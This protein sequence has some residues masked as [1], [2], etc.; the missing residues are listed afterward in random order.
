MSVVNIKGNIFTTSS[1]VVVNTINCVGVMG[2]GIALEFRLR[3]P[4]MYCRYVELCRHG[5]FAPGILW[6]Y[7]AQT[8]T[9]LN[10]PTKKDWKHPSRPEYLELGLQKFAKTYREKEI[11]TIAF[12][13]L[14]ADKGGISKDISLEIMHRYLE[15]LPNLTV[16]IYENDPEAKDDLYDVIFERL[17]QG[18]LDELSRSFNISKPILSK[19]I[20][21]LVEG[22]IFQI[23]QLGKLPGVGPSTLEKLFSGLQNNVLSQQPSLEL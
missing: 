22:Q 21:A 18:T 6:L 1:Q 7:K 15:P 14:G 9:V 13:L 2:A 12:P 16:E 11:T 5:K 20:S 10:F 8:R 23:S 19:I 17:T 3:E 4:E